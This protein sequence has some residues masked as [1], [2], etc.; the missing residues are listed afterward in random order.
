MVNQPLPTVDLAQLFPSD[1]D[2]KELDLPYYLTHFKQFAESVSLDGPNR[3]FINIPVWRR[4]KD[5]LPHNAR[6]MENCLALAFFYCTDRP[7]NPYHV[8]PAVRERLEA[9]L[10]F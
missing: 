1:F 7:W 2:D 6:I 3:G 9:A 5:N 8:H 10:N 4:P